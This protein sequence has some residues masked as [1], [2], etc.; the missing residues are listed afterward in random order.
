MIFWIVLSLY[1]CLF[2]YDAIPVIK[3]NSVDNGKASKSTLILLLF[4]LSLLDA[5]KSTLI[6]LL[7]RLN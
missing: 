5:S 1:L 6:L 7:F 4:L 3:R 2:I